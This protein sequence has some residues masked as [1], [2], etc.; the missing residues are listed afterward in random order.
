VQE[1]RRGP[2]TGAHRAVVLSRCRPPPAAA[3]RATRNP[4]KTRG[5]GPSEAGRDRRAGARRDPRPDA[6]AQGR[7]PR[8]NGL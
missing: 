8:Q 2:R 1:S 3:P 6:H 4:G 7:G 5:F